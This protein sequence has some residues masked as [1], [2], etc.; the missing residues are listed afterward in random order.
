MKTAKNR[1]IIFTICVVWIIFLI[2]ETLA[3]KWAVANNENM[4]RIDLLII[5]PILLLITI[6]T[7]IRIF[8]NDKN[9][10]N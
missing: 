1:L 4:I 8:R 2:W 10:N 7:L 3:T 6:D 9:E 5:L